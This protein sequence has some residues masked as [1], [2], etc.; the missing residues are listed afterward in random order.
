M[1]FADFQKDER[2]CNISLVKN[3]G[4]T[5]CVLAMQHYAIDQ[6]HGSILLLMFLEIKKGRLA[7]G[8]FSQT[9]RLQL[10]NCTLLFA[11]HL[12][13][14]LAAKCLRKRREV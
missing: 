10:P 1:K 5:G 14:Q 8:L 11:D 13:G 4:F 3:P 6:T 2:L 7:D 12:V 9:A